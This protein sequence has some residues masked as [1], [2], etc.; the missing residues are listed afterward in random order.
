LYNSPN[1]SIV[2]GPVGLLIVL[3]CIKNIQDSIAKVQREKT[4]AFE[5]N[6]GQVSI[7]LSAVED[8]IRKLLLEFKELKEVKPQVTAKK[9]L[10]VNLKIVLSSFTNIP[11]FTAKIQN[12]VRD[13]LQTMLGIEEEIVIKVEVRKILYSETKAKGPVVEEVSPTIPYRDYQAK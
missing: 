5:A 12:L 9:G 13:K 6:Y 8:M 10:Q 2:A 4:I 11:E 1:F 3:M 7:G